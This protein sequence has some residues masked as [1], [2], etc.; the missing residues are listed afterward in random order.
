MFIFHLPF[1]K[2]C[3]FSLFQIRNVKEDVEYYLDSNQEPDF[4]ENE[5]IY[6]DLDLE[7]IGASKLDSCMYQH[8]LLFR[9]DIFWIED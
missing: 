8:F 5:F 4:E 6:D 2:T 7:E 3:N 1:G 9:G